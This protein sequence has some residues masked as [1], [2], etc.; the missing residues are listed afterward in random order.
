M[1]LNLYFSDLFKTS[2]QDFTSPKHAK[3]LYLFNR[4]NVNIKNVI[5][6]KSVND[7]L[8]M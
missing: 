5:F 8:C 7:S 4:F 3:M 6:L 1:G 2:L